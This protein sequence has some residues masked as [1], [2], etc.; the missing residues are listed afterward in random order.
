MRKLFVHSAFPGNPLRAPSAGDDYGASDEPDWRDIDWRKHLRQNEFEGRRLN[1]VDYGEGDSGK[2]PIV[3]IHGLGGSWQNWLANIP[4]IAAEGRRTIGIDLPGHGS[5][6]MPASEMTIS[7]FGRA[8]NALCDELDL[9]EVVIVGNSMGAFTAAETAIQFPQRVERLILNSAAGMTTS[10][11]AHRPLLVGARGVVVIGA[12]AGAHSET[13]VKRKR[14]RW[15]IF[16]SFIRYPHRIPTDLLYEIAHTGR[17]GFLSALKAIFEYDYRERLPEIQCPAL[18]IWG[19]DD[20]LVPR[21]DADRYVKLIPRSR[22]VVLEDTG[23]SA[24]LER[25]PTFNDLVVEFL[26]E[27]VDPPAREEDLGDANVRGPLGSDGA[28]GS[29]P[30]ESASDG[31]AS[32]GDGLASDAAGTAS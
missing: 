30:A 29:S 9:G 12:W 17:D 25:P 20:M 16:Y 26:E 2:H 21:R 6:E 7:L 8:V 10:D 5:S 32:A 15:P 18:V 14:L 4:R 3:F 23:H 31:A 19:A 1:Y 24:M 28:N 22:K 27:V 13:L 11:L